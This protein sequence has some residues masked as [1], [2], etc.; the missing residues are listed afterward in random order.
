M[1]RIA[2]IGGG[3]GGLFASLLL[4]DYCGDL[5]E[6]TLFEA[7]PRVGGKVFT[8]QFETAPV[9]YRGP[10]QGLDA[11]RHLAEGRTTIGDGH[12]REGFVVK[13]VVERF[14]D[15]IGRVILKLHGEG[16]LTKKE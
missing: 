9:L 10:W 12:V 2:I 6:A 8:Q 15:R 13:P 16:Y 11:H 7:G 4:E 5:C 3:P 1:T 14:D